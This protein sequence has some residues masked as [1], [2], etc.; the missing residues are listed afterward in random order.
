MKVVHLWSGLIAILGIAAGLFLGVRYARSVEAEYIHALAPVH[1][2]LDITGS[3]LQEAAFEQPDLLMIYGASEVLNQKSPYQASTFFKT[4]PAGFETY[5]VAR[6]GDRMIIVAE[7]LAALGSDIRGRKVVISYTPSQFTSTMSPAAYAGLFSR[8]H[9]YQLV[10]NT[11]LTWATK[12]ML[13]TR[14]LQ[15]PKTLQQDPVLQFA[16]KQLASDTLQGHVGYDAVWPLG[17]LQTLVIELQDHFAT[18]TYIRSQKK[19]N[20]QVVRHASTINWQTLAA[21]AK[22]QQ[23]AHAN[24]NPY[25]FD[26]SIWKS[27]FAH[28]KT[29]PA[30]SGD[31]AYLTNLDKAGEW[32]DFE[33]LMRVL[34]EL[35]AEPLVL[36]RPFPA[37]YDN[38]IGVSES[39]R[40]IF[41]S[42][43]DQAANQYGVPVVEFQGHEYDKYFGVDPAPHT[44]R[45]GWVYVDQALDVFYHGS[46]P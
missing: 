44:G 1:P 45:E 39:A 42:R 38:A 29:R 43:L 14:M 46:N 35:G 16:L 24:D 18:V 32:T 12:Q 9:A 31:Q 22:T 26:N 2:P 20:P 13:A 25:G 5:E 34:T 19:L 7:A 37:Y 40:Q 15:Y 28:F 41:Y 23:R 11:R 36:G 6:G 21:T 3:A 10:F 4:Y 8:E 33:I 27:K 17:K 30:A